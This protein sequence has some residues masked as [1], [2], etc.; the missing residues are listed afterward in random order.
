MSW[1]KLIPVAIGA[2]V[3]GLIMLGIHSLYVSAVTV[4]A[5]KEEARKIERATMIENFNKATGGLAD[6]AD[7]ARLTRLGCRA[8]GGVYRFAGGKCEQG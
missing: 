3:G 1:L 7:K 8:A 2:V 6:D 4:P 5:A